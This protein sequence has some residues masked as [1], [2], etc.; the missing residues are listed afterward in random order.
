[1]SFDPSKAVLVRVI[2]VSPQLVM[3]FLPQISRWGEGRRDASTDMR[4]IDLGKH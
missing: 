1:M 3:L 2:S 4:L